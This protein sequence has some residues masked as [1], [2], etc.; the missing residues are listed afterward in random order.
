MVTPAARDLAPYLDHLRGLPF[1]RH[2]VLVTQ[3]VHGAARPDA[4][5]RLKTRTRTFTFV[6][7]AKRTFLDRALTNAVIAEHHARLRTHRPALLL[8]ARYIPRPTGERLAA[9]GVNFVDRPGNIHLNLGEDHHVLL[10]GRREPATEPTE[11]RPGPALVQLCFA[12]LAD[13][14]AAAWPV[15]TLAAAAG[16]GKTAAA[17]GLQRLLR[18]GV[19]ARARDRTCRIGDRGRLVDDFVRL[20]TQVLRPH[21]AIARFRAPEPDPDRFLNQVALA[22][23]QTDAHWAVTGGPAAYALDRFYRGSEVPLF[24]EPFTQALQRA[25]R[26]VPDRH[27]PITVLRAFGNQWAWRA[28]GDVAVA[29]PWLVYAE[30]LQ[31]GEPRALEAAEHIRERYLQP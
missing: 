23:R 11:R 22:A 30:L 21:L 4:C 18:V 31:Q 20:Y 5:V 8:V 19:L 29:H 17:T 1:V 16:T 7:E 13:P 6:L 12:L 25:L 27:G 15:R 2:V 14:A 24:V 3:P 10:V 26:L 28:I 9:A